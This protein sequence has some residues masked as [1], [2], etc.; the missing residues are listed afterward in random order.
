MHRAIPER[1]N[2]LKIDA[3]GLG[4]CVAASLLFYWATVQPFLEGRTLIA[5]QRRELVDRRD[6]VT[7]LKAGAARLQERMTGVQD[8]LATSAI[9]LEP[10]ARIN[11][12]V[13]GLTQFFSDCE[14]DV[15]DVQTGRVSNGVQYDLVP[16]TILGRGS[17]AQCVRFFR[18]LRVKFPDMNVARLEFSC[19]PGPTPRRATFKFDLLWY[20]APERP[21][22]VQ[23]AAGGT[24]G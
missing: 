12:R 7:E 1:L 24:Q 19:V 13:A 23:N 9:K 16:V 14:L 4:V 10:A 8:A 6:K 5:G 22:V 15:D 21:A 18:G 11:K 20:A 3:A 2:L 17:Y